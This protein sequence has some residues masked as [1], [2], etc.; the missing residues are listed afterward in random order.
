M[1]HKH[2][3]SDYIDR[4]GITQVREAFGLNAA[5]LS[6]WKARGIPLAKRAAFVRLA[7]DHGVTLPDEFLADLGLT[8]ANVI[9]RA[10]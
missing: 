9:G 3:H 8:I 6:M 5:H 10:A 4:V 2:P 1:V 7:D